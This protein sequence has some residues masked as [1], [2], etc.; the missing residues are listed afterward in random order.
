MI[1][2]II[3]GIKYRLDE[4]TLTAEVTAKRN[5]YEGDIIIPETVVF[6]KVTY[7]VTCIGEE[8][9]D[10]C[11][12]LTSIVI[13]DSVTS[14]GDDAFEDCSSLT[15]IVIPESVKSIGENAF[16]C[17]CSL[18]SMVVA[19]GNTVYDSR[20]QCN[21]IIHTA[22]NTLISGCQSTIIPESVTSIG[23][24]AFSHC[25]S[26]TSVVIGNGVTSIGRRAFCA[27]PLTSINIPNSVTSIGESAFE[28][29][30]SLTSIVIPDGVTSIGENAFKQCFSLT[31]I[32]IPN[33]VTSIGTW[34]FLWCNSLTSITFQGTKA[35]WKGIELIDGWNSGF[36]AKVIHCTDGEVEK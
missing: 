8:A 30:R 16:N 23:E 33:S 4:E 29:C 17:C 14:I 11:S 9:F 18:T 20:E 34:A 32:V 12:S 10:K 6:K 26:L 2:K 27:C 3:K 24:S 35:Q 13:P 19:E 31:S 36:P 7:R 25:S 22:T 15:S 5:G 28:Y 1:E 21:A